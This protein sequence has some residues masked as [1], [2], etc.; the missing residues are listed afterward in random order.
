MILVRRNKSIFWD[1]WYIHGIDH[2]NRIRTL[3]IVQKN[4]DGGYC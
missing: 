3:D 4:H 2:G 1:G